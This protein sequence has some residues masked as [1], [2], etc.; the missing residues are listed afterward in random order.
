MKNIKKSPVML[1]TPFEIAIC[2]SIES[3]KQ[4]GFARLRHVMKHTGYF[5]F[6]ILEF[7]ANDDDAPA[8]QFLMRIERKEE[9]VEKIENLR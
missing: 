1:I 3:A 9:N 2:H 6:T 4:F 5:F 7:G 8:Y